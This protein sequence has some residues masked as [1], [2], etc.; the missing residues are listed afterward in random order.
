MGGAMGGGGLGSGGQID[1]DPEDVIP[2]PPVMPRL[3]A[4]QHRNAI[5]DIFG[6][7]LPSTPLE[8]DTNPYL[9]YSIG[10]TSTEVSS[11]GVDLYAEA[12]HTIAEAVM[13][14]PQ[15]REAVLGCTPNAGDDACVEAFIDAYGRRLFRHRL[16]ADGLD[17]W[18]AL[19][20]ETADG[21]PIRGAQMALA[22]ML[23]S[24]RFLYR[25]EVGEDDP[26]RPGL[27]RYTS[28]EMASRLSFF[29]L[30]TTPDD[31]LLDAAEAGQLLDVD[32]VAT[33]ARRLLDHP[34]AQRSI[35]DFFSQY[36]DLERL[37][38]VER[39][40]AQYPGFGPPLLRAMNTEVRLLVDD[41]V[42]RQRGDIRSLFSAPRGYVNT[43]LADLY[44]VDAPGAGENIFVPV[45]FGPETPRAGLL[46]LGAFLT[47]NAHASETSPTLRGKYV[48]ERVL[49]RDIPAPPDDVDLDLERDPG[50]PPTLRERLEQHRENPGCAGCHAFID[51]PGF[52][53]ENYDS[54]GRY[55]LEAEGFPVNA[56]GELDGDPLDNALDLAE[57]LRDDGRVVRCVTRQ[58]YRHAT[59]RVDTAGEAPALARVS[60]TA[61]ATGYDF[62]EMVVA[63][64]TSDG[65]R[66]AAPPDNE[67]EGGQP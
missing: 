62:M 29:I 10:S 61:A 19:S 3:T 25:I 13:G 54:I 40:P 67:L 12:A 17:A 60:D 45:E 38:Q 27:R 57:V 42:F 1:P 15:R 53:F 30:D 18:L 22:G 43:A 28:E 33:H 39:D 50:D 47:M 66:L 24:P 64:V 7:G 56:A 2:A 31:A 52:L 36:L 37:A 5:D 14:D 44:G 16:S 20:R 41:L 32:A 8:A 23:Q 6:P 49:C 46:T 35:Q 9:F 55:R 59:G 51:P 11:A 34:R 48:L 4:A 26:D 21:V 63:L 65:F 58:L